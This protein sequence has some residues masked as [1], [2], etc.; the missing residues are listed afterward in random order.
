MSHSLSLARAAPQVLRTQSCRDHRLRYSS[1]RSKT[2]ATVVR[3]GRI[4]LAKRGA[5]MSNLR[6][7]YRHRPTSSRKLALG[8]SIS[9][10]SATYLRA[11]TEMLKMCWALRWITSAALLS[12]NSHRTFRASNSCHIGANRQAKLTRLLT[13]KLNMLTLR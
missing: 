4:L 5:Q 6:Y 8:I 12:M 3:T 10:S 11:N 9:L 7:F 13:Q 2:F 1:T